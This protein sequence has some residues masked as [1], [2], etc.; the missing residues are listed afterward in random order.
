MKTCH[1][2]VGLPASGKSTRIKDMCLMDPDVFVYSTDAFIQ[3]AASHF[4]STYDEM[5]ADN[6]KAATTSMNEM[7]AVAMQSDMNVIWDQTNLSKKKRTGIL[8]KMKS[9]GYRVECECFMPPEKTED[10]AEWNR[11]LVS[12]PGKTIPDYIIRS[13]FDNFEKPSLDEGFTNI[14]FCDIYGNDYE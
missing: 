9:A 5:F 2:M 6:I 4:N 12:R 14:E 13:M 8:N 10:V 1:I 3:E 11:R 7:L